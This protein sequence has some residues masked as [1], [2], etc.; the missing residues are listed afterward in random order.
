M[1]VSCFSVCLVL[2][3]LLLIL[4]RVKEMRFFYFYIIFLLE[5]C[6]YYHLKVPQESHLFLS[7]TN[8]QS[9]ITFHTLEV[10]QTMSTF[11]PPVL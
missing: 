11:L 7:T 3:I 10:D 4:H 2:H 5:I 9:V 8:Q 1:L 6:I